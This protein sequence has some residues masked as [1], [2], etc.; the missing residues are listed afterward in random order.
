[1]RLVGALNENNETFVP[2]II[3]IIIIGGG[4]GKIQQLI[5]LRTTLSTKKG[6]YVNKV[7]KYGYITLTAPRAGHFNF[8]APFM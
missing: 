5:V 1:M 6:Y 3:I 4:G 2:I 7:T 8:R